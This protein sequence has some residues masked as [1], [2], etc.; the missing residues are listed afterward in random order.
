MTKIRSENNCRNCGAYFQADFEIC[1]P[2]CSATGVSEM[3]SLK[4]FCQEV[5]LLQSEKKEEGSKIVSDMIK[6]RQKTI[7]KKA[8]GLFEKIEK[9]KGLPE[10]G[11]V[12]FIRQ[13]NVLRLLAR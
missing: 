6:Q 1:C 5:K 3:L 11:A 7:D 10:E 9:H 12:L 2:G 4:H 13:N 8:E